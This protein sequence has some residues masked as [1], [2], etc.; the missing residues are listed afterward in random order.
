VKTFILKALN[1]FRLIIC[2]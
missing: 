2:C 1:A